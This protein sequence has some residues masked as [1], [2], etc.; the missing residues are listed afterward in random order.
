MRW[1]NSTWSRAPDCRR[2]VL[3]WNA[4]TRQARR[5]LTADVCSR[6]AAAWRLAARLPSFFPARPATCGSSRS[7]R[8]QDAA[9]RRFLAAAPGGAWPQRPPGPQTADASATTSVRQYYADGPSHG[10]SLTPQHRAQSASS[11]LLKIAYL[12]AY[13]PS[14][15]DNPNTS[16]G[17]I[18]RG[19]VNLTP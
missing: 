16:T 1:L 3:R 11:A 10:R 15:G 19:Q 14:I 7:M 5:A 18:I 4:K 6:D 9:T 8:P 2:L 13:L 17:R 12:S